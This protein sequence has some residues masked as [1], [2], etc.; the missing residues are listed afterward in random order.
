MLQ[1][2]VT[3]YLISPEFTTNGA[4]AKAW[5]RDADGSLWL[6]KLNDRQSTAKIEVMV[7]NILDCTNVKHCHY[8]AREDM[9][10]YVCACPAMTSDTLSIVDGLTF[11][12]YCNKI[13]VDPD[14]YIKGIIEMITTR[15]SL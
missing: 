4:Y 7:S 11:I 2:Y 5:H 3:E 1:T 15:C 10:Y 8:E 13:N 14:T 9:G 12:G 6:Y